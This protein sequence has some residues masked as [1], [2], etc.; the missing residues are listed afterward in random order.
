MNV[1]F[2][3]YV[4]FG[5]LDLGFFIFFIFFSSHTLPP[6]AESGADGFALVLHNDPAGLSALGAGGGG[7]GYMGEWVVE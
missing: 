7:L 4:L 2:M 5:S 1:Y 6:L 3:F